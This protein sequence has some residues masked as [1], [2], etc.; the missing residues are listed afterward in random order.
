MNN[1]GD[2]LNQYLGMPSGTVSFPKSFPGGFDVHPGLSTS[3]GHVLYRT[4]PV[5]MWGQCGETGFSSVKDG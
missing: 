3:G 2:I 1:T 5:P 4:D